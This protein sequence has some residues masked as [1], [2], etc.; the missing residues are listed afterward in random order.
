M[1]L[2]LFT[3]GLTEKSIFFQLM[4][5]YTYGNLPKPLF[6]HATTTEIAEA[7]PKRKQRG[8]EATEHIFLFI[9]REIIVSISLK[10][11]FALFT[12]VLRYSCS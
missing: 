2:L 7:S 9:V 10:I 11:Y 4:V 12:C 5:E 8:L 3:Q 1:V 6:S